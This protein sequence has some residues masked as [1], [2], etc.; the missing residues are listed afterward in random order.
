MMVCTESLSKIQL[1]FATAADPQQISSIFNKINLVRY[2][3]LFI[4]SFQMF[5]VILTR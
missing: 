1:N 4:I 5:S 2:I 3:N